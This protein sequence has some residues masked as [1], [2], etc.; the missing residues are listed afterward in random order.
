MDALCATSLWDESYLL[1]SSDCR[2]R[3][4]TLT[5]F[6]CRATVHYQSALPTPGAIKPKIV[7]SDIGLHKRARLDY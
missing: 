6:A 5:C 1:R 3:I 4:G 7:Y 2:N